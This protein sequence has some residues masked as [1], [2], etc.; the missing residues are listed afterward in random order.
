MSLIYWAPLF[1]ERAGFSVQ[2]TWRGQYAACTV[3]VEAGVLILPCLG[4]GQVERGVF[5]VES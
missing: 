1:R 4:I 3:A 5:F 2:M